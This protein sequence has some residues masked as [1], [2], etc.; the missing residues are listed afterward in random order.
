MQLIFNFKFGNKRVNYLFPGLLL[1]LSSLGMYFKYTIPNLTHSVRSEIT[2]VE[3]VS[4]FKIIEDEDAVIFSSSSDLW[5]KSLSSDLRYL[6]NFVSIKPQ[7]EL[8]NMIDGSRQFFE[9][10]L[11]SEM[12]E[13]ARM[14]A[15]ELNGWSAVYVSPE[16]DYWRY[17]FYPAISSLYFQATIGI[18][19]LFGVPSGKTDRA[20]SLRSAQLAGGTLK[21]IDVFNYSK[22]LCEEASKWNI[23]NVI[24]FGSGQQEIN[25]VKC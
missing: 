13:K 16:N 5:D 2:R 25:V 21:E 4:R 18:P 7:D 10:T 24:A 11:P 19:M 20:Y 15:L 3:E 17:P 22:S 6:F 9:D 23:Q 14:I 12:A 8:R 1:V